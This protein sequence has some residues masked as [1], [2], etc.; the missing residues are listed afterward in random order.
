MENNIHI[1]GRKKKYIY[2]YTKTEA[3][4]KHFFIGIDIILGTK[5]VG[6]RAFVDTYVIN[7]IVID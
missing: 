2:I 3:R 5:M 1:Y 4:R 7:N 6:A